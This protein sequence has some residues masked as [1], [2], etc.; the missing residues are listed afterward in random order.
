MLIPPSLLVGVLLMGAL[1]F[2]AA[3]SV[4][5]VDGWAFVLLWALAITIPNLA[6]ARWNPGLLRRRAR[7]L[8]QSPR[9]ERVLKA[10]Y[11]PLILV[12][13]A[14]AGL[15]AVRFGWSEQSRWLTLPG[16][17]L[18]VAGAALQVWTML[19]NTHYEAGMRI[20]RGHAV[21]RVGPYRVV[22]HPGYLAAIIQTA[23]APLV[24]RS[25][26][27]WLPVVGI[28]AVLVA[29]VAFEDR[30]L[31]DQLDGYPA[32]ARQVRFRLVPGIW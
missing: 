32:Y 3:G 18:L 14:V 17:T 5:W 25:A 13:P 16:V 31:R 11:T 21:V 9:Y 26:W 2:L 20:Q 23:G 4:A 15:D 8:A 30:A 24:L 1:G 19:T 6:L 27:A 7:G 10:I 22:R 28:A 12:L 29:R